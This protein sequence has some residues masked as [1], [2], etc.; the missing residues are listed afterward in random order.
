MKRRAVMLTIEAESGVALKTLE[1]SVRSALKENFYTKEL[2][3][4]TVR[5][6]VVQSVE[7]KKHG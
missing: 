6:Q 4:R 5:V 7:S 3:I 2:E 1:D